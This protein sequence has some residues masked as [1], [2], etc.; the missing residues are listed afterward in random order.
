MNLIDAAGTR[1]RGC[2]RAVR[3]SNLRQQTQGSLGRKASPRPSLCSVFAL[4]L[5]GAPAGAAVVIDHTLSAGG[6]L[7]GP[8]YQVTANLGR[9]VG[10]NLFFSFS[11]FNLLQGES[12]T[13]SGPGSVS[14]IISRVTSGQASSIDGQMNSTIS[15]ADLYFI[16]PAGVMFGPDATVNISG[17]F[18]VSSAHYLKLADGGRFD[19]ANP[20]ASSLTS[21]APEA[22]GFLGG[23]GSISFQGSQI[24]MQPGAALSVIGG[25]VTLNGALLSAPGGSVNI[26]STDAMDEVSLSASGAASGCP[27]SGNITLSNGALVSANSAG[28]LAS[29]AIFVGGGTLTLNA[30]AI[31]S[32]NDSDLPGGNITVNAS[33][34]LNIDGGG[35]PS[36][37]GNVQSIYSLST[38]AGA[39]GNISLNTPSLLL[40]DFGW[41]DTQAYGSG[42]GGSIGITTQNMQIL[43]Q[44]LLQSETFGSG[45]GGAINVNASGTLSVNGGLIESLSFGGGKGGDQTYTAASLLLS[46]GGALDAEAQGSADGGAINV[47]AGTVQLSTG[48]FINTATDTFGNPGVTGPIGNAGNITIQASG[49]VSVVG[50]GSSG[51]GNTS[52]IGSF[53]FTNGSAGSILINAP[54]VQ[55][56]AEGSVSASALS[57][58]NGGNVTINAQDVAVTGGSGILAGVFNGD[59]TATGNAAAGNI[60][61]NASHSLTLS[62]GD[63]NYESQIDILNQGSGGGAGGTVKISTSLLSIDVNSFI[64]ADVDGASLNPGSINITA[65]TIDL[66]GVISASAHASG[67]GPS[68]TIMANHA[69]TLENNATIFTD[70]EGANETGNAGKLTISAPLLTVDTGAL[71][72]TATAGAG[73]GGSISI[74]GTDFALFGTVT[75]QSTGSGPAGNITLDLADALNMQPG[76]SISTQ[77]ASADG[78]NI[79]ISVGRLLYLDQAQITASA[80]SGNVGTGN[81]GNIKLDPQFLV[82]NRASILANAFGGNGGNISITASRFV[83]S[84]DSLVQASSRFGVN[85]TIDVSSPVVDIG[86]TLGRLPADYLDA[87]RFLRRG[88][89]SRSGGR[90]SS[91]VAAGRGGLPQGADSPLYSPMSALLDLGGPAASNAER[92]SNAAQEPALR[93]DSAL[94]G[95]ADFAACLASS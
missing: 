46:N 92:R 56:G 40:A 13:F 23:Q 85:G 16:N 19:A 55:I 93:S 42:N 11:Q 18:Y 2:R 30:S 41:I 15:G 59:P 88:C 35:A 32:E 51:L 43:S 80:G 52:T 74:Q 81:G 53:S 54:Q 3:V 37:G 38:A 83:P 36:G 78:G 29:G 5:I 61:I 26:A 75:A 12:A 84:A 91:F 4:A 10:S 48:S 94:D 9:Q 21:A 70:A 50:D 60:T 6:A 95:G 27:L 68:L 65:D 34:A 8:S 76:A 71:I 73:N 20:S 1:Q 64:N 77:T 22:F 79:N 82:L 33:Q 90:S 58:G 31:G 63:P 89:A 44:A 66:A 17:S 57:N 47:N 14:R 87:S 69:L 25:D 45:L 49:T 86:Q 67:N 24:V 39:G 72:T 28:N 7:A 62:S